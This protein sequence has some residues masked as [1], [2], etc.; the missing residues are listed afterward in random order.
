M[1]ANE[2]DQNHDHIPFG[3]MWTEQDRTKFIMLAKVCP[4]CDVKLRY[5][6]LNKFYA[7]ASEMQNREDHDPEDAEFLA[8]AEAIAGRSQE[9]IEITVQLADQQ[10]ISN[11]MMY[12]GML[13]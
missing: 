7:A 3:Q 10:C 8:L 6:E 1:D 5:A 9:L 13:N 12:R 2:F 4:F 11:A